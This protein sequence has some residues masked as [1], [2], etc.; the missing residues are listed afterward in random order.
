MAKTIKTSII[1]AFMLLLYATVN[2]QQNNHHLT[3]LKTENNMENKNFTTTITVKKS[4]QEVFSCIT[5]VTNWWSK[6]F[7]GSSTILHDEFVIHHSGLHYSKQK[8]VDVIP[9]KKMVWLVTDSTLYWLQNDQHEWTNTK[10]IFE[11]TTAGNN[12][13]LNF[14]HEGLVP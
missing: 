13:I 4:A 12:T 14:I 6:D 1:L 2:A 10:M 3:K 7:E 9:N 5:D 8:L 11:I